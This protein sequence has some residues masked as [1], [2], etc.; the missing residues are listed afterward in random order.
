[1]RLGR[2]VESPSQATVVPS[3]SIRPIQ[4]GRN[5]NG[6][7]NHRRVMGRNLNARSH[8]VESGETLRPRPMTLWPTRSVQFSAEHLQSPADLANETNGSNAARPL[9]VGG[10]W[11]HPSIPTGDQKSSCARAAMMLAS[12]S[13]LTGLSSIAWM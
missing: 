5:A 1:M 7:S 11:R 3:T 4:L 13:P 6:K 8:R 12:L 10:I 9:R 2:I